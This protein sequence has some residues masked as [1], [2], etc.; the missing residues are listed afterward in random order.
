MARSVEH[1]QRAQHLLSE[2]AE[3]DLLGVVDANGAIELEPLQRLSGARR[4]AVLRAWLRREGLRMPPYRRLEEFDRQLEQA[5]PESRATLEVSDT[6]FAGG[7][8][9]RVCLR[10]HTLRIERLSQD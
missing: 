8:P 5:G 9:F 7:A 1:V 6:A 3:A 2:Q 10:A 4:M